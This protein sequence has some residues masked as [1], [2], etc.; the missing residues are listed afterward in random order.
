ME[1]YDRTNKFT[2]KTYIK[3]AWESNE[4]VYVDDIKHIEDSIEYLGSFFNYP[5]NWQISKKWNLA[6]NNNISY[7]DLNRW[8]NN[9]NAIEKVIKESEPKY[10]TEFYCGEEVSL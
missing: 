1:I 5:S 6:G 7:V 4:L 3:K 2:E 8:I 9:L 10:A